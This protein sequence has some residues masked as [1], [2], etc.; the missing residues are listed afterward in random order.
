ML[1]SKVARSGIW[2]NAVSCWLVVSSLVGSLNSFSFFFLTIALKQSNKWLAKYIWFDLSLVGLG[3]FAQNPPFPI[4]IYI[5][6]SRRVQRCKNV[7]C[8]QIQI[9]FMQSKQERRS[10]H[11]STNASEER[12]SIHSRMFSFC[13]HTAD[14]QFADFR[15]IGMN[16]AVNKLALQLHHRN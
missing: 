13:S 16:V 6:L 3:S 15:F 10:L 9:D 14:T 7:K 11:F 1:E 4:A 8:K 12:F 2:H 5:W